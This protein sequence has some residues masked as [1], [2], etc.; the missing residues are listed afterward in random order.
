MGESF[1]IKAISP[2]L[3]L[4]VDSM[5]K[6]IKE[7]FNINLGKIQASKVIAWKSKNSQLQLTD[8]R[9]LK[10]LGGKI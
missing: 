8:E 4:E 6:K 10:I 1:V 5:I 2:E 7:A 3:S 9:L